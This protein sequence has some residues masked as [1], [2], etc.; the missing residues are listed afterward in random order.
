MILKNKTLE[1]YEKLK[2]RFRDLESVII[3][4]SGGIDSTLVVKV[5]TDELKQNAI[6]VIGRSK[7]LPESEYF[8][9]KKIANEIGANI[10]EI[11]TEETD[12]LKFKSNPIDRCYYCKNELFGKLEEIAIEKNINW[13]CDGS[14]V[15]DS[16]DFRPGTKARKE[17]NIISPL[18]EIG[19]TKSDVRELAEF[20]KLSNFD[21]PSSPCL[22]SRFPYGTEITDEKL[23]RIEIAEDFMKELG[24]KIVRVRFHDEKTARIEVMQNEIAKLYQDNLI[25]K[26]IIKFKEI[27]FTYIT[28]D[29]EGFRSGSMN[30]VLK[31]ET[32]FNL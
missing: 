31:F 10:L 4:F 22:S 8:A 6:A 2:L 7:T 27:G 26:I 1:K 28:V 25:S 11:F 14:I 9:A 16:F 21:K 32:N 29:L 12:D 24:F 18:L 13:I 30:E 19:F 20:L 3:G 15:D 17:K 23:L 5:A